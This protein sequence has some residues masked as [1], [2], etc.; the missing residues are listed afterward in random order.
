MNTTTARHLQANETSC[1]MVT[2]DMRH[3]FMP[4]NETIKINLPHKT[5]LNATFQSH[6][7]KWVVAAQIRSV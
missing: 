6:P 4:I 2:C 1:H 7:I 3:I 5:M